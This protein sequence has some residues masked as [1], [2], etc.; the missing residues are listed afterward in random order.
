MILKISTLASK[1][2]KVIA[3]VHVKDLYIFERVH[4][5]IPALA[6][7]SKEHGIFKKVSENEYT[8]TDTSKYGCFFHPGSGIVTRILKF[9][10]RAQETKLNKNDPIQLSVGDEI[11]I[12]APKGDPRGIV[13]RVVSLED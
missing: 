11:I 5:E 3:V 6:F 12:R 10:G 8:Y 13:I 2:K 7:I 4:A 1:G 9:F